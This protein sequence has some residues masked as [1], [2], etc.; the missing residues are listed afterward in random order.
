MYGYDLQGLK[1]K[2]KEIRISR[3]AGQ[4]ERINESGKYNRIWFYFTSR[5]SETPIN[6]V[7]PQE[8]LFHKAKAIF[9]VSEDKIDD[10]FIRE[11]SP[12]NFRPK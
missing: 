2:A 6:V 9:T 10:V 4:H 3:Q 7:I 5:L 8:E 1:D 11:E 12:D